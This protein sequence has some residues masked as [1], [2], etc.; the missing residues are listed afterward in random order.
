[1]AVAAA[2]PKAQLSGAV[3]SSLCSEGLTPRLI[4][5]L[6][7]CIG[8]VLTGAASGAPPAQAG[9]LGER[10]TDKASHRSL[11]PTGPLL[12]GRGP[13]TAGLLSKGVRCL[14]ITANEELNCPAA[15]GW[16]FRLLCG[17]GRGLSV[18]L[19]ALLWPTHMVGRGRRLPLPSVCG[20]LWG[21]VV[22]DPQPQARA[23][24]LLICCACIWRLLDVVALPAGICSTGRACEGSLAR[25]DL[26]EGA[27]GLCTGCRYGECWAGRNWDV[28]VL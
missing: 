27:L 14:L 20:A 13:S 7:L 23:F 19:L 28:S 26:L 21:G 24:A 6:G 5:S 15:H 11:L 2:Q 25:Y 16:L 1:M 12:L 17:W 9:E 10:V 3:I 4:K 22:P 8:L 18:C